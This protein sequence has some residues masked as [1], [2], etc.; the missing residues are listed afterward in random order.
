MNNTI[1][2]KNQNGEY[3]TYEIFD[4]SSDYKNQVSQGSFVLPG[5]IKYFYYDK[6]EVRLHSSSTDNLIRYQF[7]RFP[8]D[9]E[10]AKEDEYTEFPSEFY[11][12]V[13]FRL[14]NELDNNRA[15]IDI[16]FESETESLLVNGINYEK[17][18][19]IYSGNPNPIISNSNATRNVNVILYDINHGIIGF[20][21]LD[22]NQWRITN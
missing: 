1:K 14:W 20:D 13:F 21:D 3:I 8:I 2:Y 7:S 10:Q 16:D 15:E 11:G 4:V 22:N 17:V 18:I 19:K 12:S 9:F 6:K 5:S